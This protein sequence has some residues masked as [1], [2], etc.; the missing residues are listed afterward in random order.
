MLSYNMQRKQN[1]DLA[2]C[3]GITSAVME[4][5]LLK[6]G[7]GAGNQEYAPHCGIQSF[8]FKMGRMYNSDQCYSKEALKSNHFFMTLGDGA[9]YR[10]RNQHLSCLHAL[11]LR[12]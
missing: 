1:R 12:V 2:S 8:S 3:P 4:T 9:V 6:N 10:H 11:I 5:K 7:K